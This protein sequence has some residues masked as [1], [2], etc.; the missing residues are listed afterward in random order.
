MKKIFTLILLLFLLGL[1]NVLP[2]PIECPNGTV[3][4]RE[5]FDHYDD[6]LNPASPIFSREPL[7]A[8]MTTYNFVDY[9]G[10][11]TPLTGIYLDG[12]YAI[13]KHSI[14]AAFVGTERNV[15][16]R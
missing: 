5:T 13:V 8:G 6:G 16:S 7:P 12:N 4:W 14:A 1:A 10:T 2:L 9:V 11:I 3:I 15:L